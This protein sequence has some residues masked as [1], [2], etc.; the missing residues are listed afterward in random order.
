[1]STPRLDVLKEVYGDDFERAKRRFED[2]YEKFKKEFPD[3]EPEFFTAPGRTE[4]IGN[5][6][7]HNGGH[8][9]AGSI[10]LD[11]I[12]AAAPNGTN[13]LHL[14]NEGYGEF[15]IDVTRPE[16][17][18]KESGTISLLAG[19]TEYL[20]KNGFKIG[21][22]DVYVTT[23]VISSAGVSSSASFE[24]LLMAIINHLF[25]D[26]NLSFSDYAK[27]GQYAE[28]VYWNKA[29]GLMDQMACA[30]GGP[31]LLSFKDE[32]TYEK[33]P[34]GFGDYGYDM[35]IINTGKG[36]ADLSED[37]SAVPNEM[38]AVAKA[39]GADR[40]CNTSLEDLIANMNDVVKKVDNDR[41]ILRAIHYFTED[42]RV[43]D[44]VDAVSKKDFE[45]ILSLIKESGISSYD[46]LQ[47][48]FTNA[49]P[50]EQK[51]TLA[52]AITR[53]FLEKKGRG[54][55][56]VHGGGFA[57]VIQTILPHEDLD[58]Y[59]KYMSE[60]FGKENVYPMN[61]RAVGAAHLEK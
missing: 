39:L 24:M 16:D 27:A 7:D 55:C 30:V 58:E 61:V 46:Q 60:Y 45:T 25:N 32:I 52:L 59:V 10:S 40:L 3:S 2:I 11:S 56:R 47:N 29:S 36:H 19:M 12:G 35:V 22:F 17:F 13:T 18:P 21:G 54:I 26:G 48:V 9:I 57:G 6:T 5:H 34:F 44:M 15:S 31:I 51:I 50:T 53:L 42:R 49:N 1:M 28:N 14:F 20:N 41:A 43:L 4:I 33:I 37:Y 8:V 38:K 23:E